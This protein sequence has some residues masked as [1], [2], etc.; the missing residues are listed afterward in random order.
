MALVD[1]QTHKQLAQTV[2]SEVG[3][4]NAA[5]NGIASG[6]IQVVSLPGQKWPCVWS[7]ASNTRVFGSLKFT[8]SKILDSRTLRSFWKVR[9]LEISAIISS[10]N[11]KM[12]HSN[13]FESRFQK[14]CLLKCRLQN[15]ITIRLVICS[16]SLALESLRG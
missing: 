12:N 7:S 16:L 4:F 13:E 5:M 2:P 3:I 9:T 1:V 15:A 10:E 8:L 11:F 14:Q 6:L